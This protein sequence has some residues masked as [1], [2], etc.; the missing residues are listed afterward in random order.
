MEAALNKGPFPRFCSHAYLSHLFLLFSV[1]SCA[2]MCVRS[3]LSEE[4]SDGRGG[5]S[6]LAAWHY[7]SECCSYCSCFW[8][9]SIRYS[10]AALSGEA[11]TARKAVLLVLRW[12]CYPFPRVSSFPSPCFLGTTS[13][14]CVFSKWPSRVKST[15]RR[16]STWTS[17][18]RGSSRWFIAMTP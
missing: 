3:D 14:G 2:R 5:R 16:F 12:P 4:I 1:H 18:W 9:G 11:V 6:T 15:S 10:L 13:W 17:L 7:S 8:M